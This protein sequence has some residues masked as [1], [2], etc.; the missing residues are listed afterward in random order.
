MRAAVLRSPGPVD[1]NPLQIEELQTP[2]PADDEVLLK[3][4]ACGVCH[5][6]LHIA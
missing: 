1:A 6:D 2:S 5:T 3:V 4:L